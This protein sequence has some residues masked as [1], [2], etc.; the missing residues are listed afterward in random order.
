[1]NFLQ[2]TLQKQSI[3]KLCNLAPVIS[4]NMVPRI[5]FMTKHLMVFAGAF[6]MHLTNGQ[7]QSV[8]Q[9]QISNEHVFEVPRMD[10]FKRLPDFKIRLQVAPDAEFGGFCESRSLLLMKLTDTD[11]IKVLHILEEMGL[12]YYI[13]ADPSFEKAIS[14]CDNP[15]EIEISKTIN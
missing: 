8:A 10:I 1:M 6:L 7:A 4:V 13:K 2:I 14:A 3:C 15:K 12:T 11:Y 9:K 5:Y